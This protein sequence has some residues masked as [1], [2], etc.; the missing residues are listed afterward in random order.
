[1]LSQQRTK[2]LEDKL[3]EVNDEIETATALSQD[4]KKRQ[5]EAM[6]KILQDDKRLII[7]QAD[8]ICTTLEGCC[9]TEMETIF[10][11]YDSNISFCFRK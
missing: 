11:E 10:L 8:V 1:M 6:E 2:D 4:T 7:C 9:S 3:N 5:E